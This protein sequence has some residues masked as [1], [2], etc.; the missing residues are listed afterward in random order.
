MKNIL[1]GVLGI[2]LAALLVLLFEF[3]STDNHLKA[4]EDDGSVTAT[5]QQETHN[6]PAVENIQISTSEAITPVEQPVEEYTEVEIPAESET[7]EP[8][9]EEET[10]EEAE[11]T[12]DPVTDTEEPEVDSFSGTAKVKMENNGSVRIGDTVRLYA[13]VSNIDTPYSV[14]WQYNDGEKWYDIA[15][16]TNT[17]YEFIV[18][19]INCGYAYRVVIDY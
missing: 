14:R 16:E 11:E 7:A 6:E 10:S 9:A 1:K 3:S 8:S 13:E 4:S 12:A 19:D 17:E 18:D 15:G 2:S 5:E